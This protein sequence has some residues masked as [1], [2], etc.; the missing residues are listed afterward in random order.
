MPFAFDRLADYFRAVAALGA[1][2]DAQKQRA[3]AAL[4]GLFEETPIPA[5]GKGEPPFYPPQP[6]PETPAS[7]AAAPGESSAAEPVRPPSRPPRRRTQVEHV[8]APRRAPP[9][10]PPWLEHVKPLPPPRAEVVPPPAPMPLLAYRWS[11]AILSTAMAT[12]TRTNAID[13][14]A[15][16]DA[17]SRGV[18]LRRVPLRTLP[19]LS[20]GVQLLVD[21]GPA[22]PPFLKDQ[23]LLVQQVTVVA[24]SDRV[25]VLRFDPSRGFIAGKGPRTRWRA[26]FTLAPPPPRA[27]VVLI[28]DLGITNVPHESSAQPGQWL[29]FLTRLGARGN[30]V[31]AFVPYAPSRWPRL[32][33]GVADLVLW[34]QRT[35]VQRVQRLA[36]RRVAKRPLLR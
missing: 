3:I 35:S 30:R 31:L 25:Q 5:A 10:R 11:R 4:L 7:T 15:V 9:E 1:A 34:D 12:A 27:T 22:S 24:G 33:H 16:I 36:G 17:V 20:H 18:P 21:R 29:E 6:E 19:T 32:P 26:Y 2:G 8:I 28:S 23:D 13:V 14:E